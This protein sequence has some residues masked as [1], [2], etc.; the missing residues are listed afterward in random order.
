MET[1]KTLPTEC[2]T[3]GKTALQISPM[4]IGTWQWGDRIVWDYGKGGFSDDDLRPGFQVSLQVGINFFDTAEAYGSGRSETLLGQQVRACG[5]NLVIA[6]KFVPYPW[7]IAKSNLKVALKHSLDRLGLEELDLYQIHLPLPPHPVTFWADA[8]A[9]VVYDGLV[10]A[11]GVSNFSRDQMRR[12]YDVLAK[13]GI[14]LASNQVRYNLFDHSPEKNGVLPACRELG[15]TLIAYSPLAQGLLTGKY[16]PQKPLSGTRGIQLNRHL[17][18]LQ[19]Q[20]ELMRQIGQAHN[21]KSPA[22]V[23]LNWLICKGVVPIPGA[24]NAQQATENAGALGWRLNESEIAV[25]E[26][27]SDHK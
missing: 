17:G 16:T 5:R 15:V 22:Q 27:A 14:P 25:L 8:L 10:K 9:D 21:H 20:I 7:R 11:V 23:A 1:S 24:K 19:P 3:L 2:I 13:R 18:N 26:A 12:A 4:G 6:S